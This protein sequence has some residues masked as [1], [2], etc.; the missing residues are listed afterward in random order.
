MLW[1]LECRLAN[2]TLVHPAVEHPEPRLGDAPVVRLQVRPINPQALQVPT[3]DSPR[4]HTQRVVEILS[5]RFPLPQECK[6]AP[7]H[8]C[9]GLWNAGWPTA[10]WSTRRWSTQNRDSATRL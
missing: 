1:S 5:G 7:R 8:G 9:Y 10:R 2:R 4:I 3:G 6:C